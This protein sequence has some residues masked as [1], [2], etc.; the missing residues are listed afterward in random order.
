MCKRWQR[1]W[2]IL[3]EHCRIDQNELL[4]DLNRAP[5]IMIVRLSQ[6]M[7]WL[8]VLRCQ[9]VSYFPNPF[10]RLS[11]AI[12]QVGRLGRDNLLLHCRSRHSWVCDDSYNVSFQVPELFLFPFNGFPMIFQ[13]QFPGW[14]LVLNRLLISFALVCLRLSFALLTCSKQ[15]DRPVSKTLPSS[16]SSTYCQDFYFTH[17]G[18]K[19]KELF[20]K[21]LINCILVPYINTFCRNKEIPSSSLFASVWI[22]EH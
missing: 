4:K 5:Q 18:T 13:P 2:L 11:L 8:Y 21:F 7:T 17:K 22:A 19:K 16:W 20:P 1:D 14:L 3:A 10:L 12:S 6:T 9:L 15:V